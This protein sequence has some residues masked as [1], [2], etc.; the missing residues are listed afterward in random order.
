V[1]PSYAWRNWL[2]GRYIENTMGP[3]I[4]NWIDPEAWPLGPTQ[5]DDY[6]LYL[7]EIE[8]SA[9]RQLD[10][11]PVRPVGVAL[12]LQTFDKLVLD[13]GATTSLSVTVCRDRDFSPCSVVVI[14]SRMTSRSPE[15]LEIASAA[16]SVLG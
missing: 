4:P 9:Q 6:V 15:R 3:V 8:E 13:S 16:R 10:A 11:Q 5:T 12:G 7:T 14:D 2:W 1:Y